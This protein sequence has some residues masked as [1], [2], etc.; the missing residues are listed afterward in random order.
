MDEKMFEKDSSN[1]DPISFYTA[2]IFLKI[3]VTEI[4][5]TFFI[6]MTYFIRIFPKIILYD[7]K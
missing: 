1:D 3:P 7:L 5:T 2:L 6:H 4:L